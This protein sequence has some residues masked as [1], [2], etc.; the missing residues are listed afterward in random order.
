MA[1]TMPEAVPWQEQQQG[2][3]K[4]KLLVKSSSALEVVT[5]GAV[6]NGGVFVEG[7][8][9]SSR[10]PAQ[11]AGDAALHVLPEVAVAEELRLQTNADIR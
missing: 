11:V 8:E 7:P 1:E 5:A 9:D 3:K 4:G 6:K 10:R 2:N